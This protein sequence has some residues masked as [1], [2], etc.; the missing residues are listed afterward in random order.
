M[1]VK[2][3]I[4]FSTEFKK[5][6]KFSFCENRLLNE[7]N[8]DDEIIFVKF[9]D[10]NV[11]NLLTIFNEHFDENNC[12]K[13]VNFNLFRQDTLLKI[14]SRLIE[15]SDNYSGN[16]KIDLSDELICPFRSDKFNEYDGNNVCDGACYFMREFNFN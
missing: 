4:R 12:P 1:D 9:W 3:I 11:I 6:I 5:V 10:N 15:C 13:W 14:I 2:D 16:D 7:K 8:R